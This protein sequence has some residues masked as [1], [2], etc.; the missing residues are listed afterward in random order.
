MASLAPAAPTRTTSGAA[1]GH[2]QGGR[3]TAPPSIT[4]DRPK[5]TTVA[6]S[7]FL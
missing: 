1:D 6:L 4:S 5:S 3:R 2:F 7:P